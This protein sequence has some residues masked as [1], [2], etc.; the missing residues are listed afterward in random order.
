VNLGGGVTT[1]FDATAVVALHIDTV[2]RPFVEQELATADTDVC[3]S[4]LSLTEALAVVDRLTGE[5]SLRLD[6]EDALRAQWDRYAVVPVDQRCLDRATVLLREQPLR[7]ADAI[8]LAAADRLPRP[9]RY[10]TFDPVQI[11]AALGLG[12]DVVA[13]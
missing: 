8:Q 7:V 12:F 2:A 13:R 10:V 1:F 5:P 6:L 4:A 9:I 3:V 11:P